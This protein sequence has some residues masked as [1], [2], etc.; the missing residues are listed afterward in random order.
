MQPFFCRLRNW[1][2]GQDCCLTCA[3]CGK[4]EAVCPMDIHIPDLIRSIRGKRKRDLMAECL[5]LE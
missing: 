3:M 5:V 2:F 4:C 1:P